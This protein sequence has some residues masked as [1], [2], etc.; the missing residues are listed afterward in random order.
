MLLNKKIFVASAELFLVH[1]FW[2]KINDVIVC[3]Q[4][5][6]VIGGHVVIWDIIF[7]CFLI[8]LYTI[9]YIK[10]WNMSFLF[11]SYTRAIK[12]VMLRST[13]PGENASHGYQALD[14]LK[15]VSFTRFRLNVLNWTTLSMWQRWAIL[16]FVF[17]R[18]RND[19]DRLVTQIVPTGEAW[20]SEDPIQLR[21]GVP[22]SYGIIDYWFREHLDPS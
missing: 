11:G 2:V 21:W 20:G 10:S 18:Y 4:E 3:W 6:F 12:T 17:L 13:N 5:L 19:F 8:T 7:G 1:F 14:F 9:Q 22:F 16:F 15:D